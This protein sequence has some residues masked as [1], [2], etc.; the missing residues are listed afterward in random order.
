MKIPKTY[1]EL[2]PGKDSLTAEDGLCEF[3]E[4]SLSEFDQNYINIFSSK[5]FFI[6]VLL[7][8]YEEVYNHEKGFSLHPIFC[9]IVRYLLY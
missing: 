5:A 2:V 9:L 3:Y 7:S 8:G 4:N 6:T 1:K